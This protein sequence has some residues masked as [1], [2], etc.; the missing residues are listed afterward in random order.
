MKRFLIAWCACLAACGVE[1]PPPPVQVLAAAEVEELL[2]VDFDRFSADTG[3][4]VT[5]TW[6]DSA[7]LADQLIDK[8]GG[9]ADE[10]I[11]SNAA[12]K[13]RAAD[14]GALRPIESAAL[15]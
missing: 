5:L 14:R 8:S 9:P 4:P 10:I 3:I 2:A 1:P 15:E 11:T 6:G 13:W 12:D 7:A